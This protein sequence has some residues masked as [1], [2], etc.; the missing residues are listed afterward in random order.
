MLRLPGIPA[1]HHRRPV[2]LRRDGLHDQI[3]HPGRLCHHGLF[4]QM[5]WQ[6]ANRRPATERHAGDVNPQA[7]QD[8][9]RESPNLGQ[10]QR[11]TGLGRLAWHPIQSLPH[12]RNSSA[13]RNPSVHFHRC[14]KSHL[15]PGLPKPV[16]AAARRKGWLGR[17]WRDL[18]RSPSRRM[19]QY[20]LVHDRDAHR[21]AAPSVHLW[22]VRAE[23]PTGPASHCRHLNRRSPGLR[24]RSKPSWKLPE[25]N[26][27]GQKT[28]P[29]LGMGQQAAPPELRSLDFDPPS[30]HG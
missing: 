30:E 16:E 7:S 10:R 15:G 27:R 28:V 26:H 18:V 5:A 11:L 6:Q 8:A 2:P 29:P 3:A 12:R 13:I 24:R 4:D 21:L 19:D 1:L 17:A 9:P 23:A 25:A 20:S 14:G 22:R